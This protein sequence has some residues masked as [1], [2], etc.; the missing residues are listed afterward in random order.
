MAPDRMNL[1]AEQ[2]QPRLEMAA[3]GKEQA[4]P[5]PPTEDLEVTALPIRAC[6]VGCDFSSPYVFQ[7]PALTT[8]VIATKSKPLIRMTHV[9]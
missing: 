6:R 5:S 4:F 3:E 9:A 1:E 7:S 8:R 2:D